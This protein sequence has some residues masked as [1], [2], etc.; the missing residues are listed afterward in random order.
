MVVGVR[1][2]AFVWIKKICASARIGARGRTRGAALRAPIVRASGGQESVR[3][4]HRRLERAVG[5]RETILK[6]ACA[7]APRRAPR[8]HRH[9]AE[10]SHAAQ[11]CTNAVQRETSRN[12]LLFLQIRVS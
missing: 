12:L 5:A 7:H 8:R 1:R 3:G 2:H 11:K 4:A 10:K 6:T 9:G